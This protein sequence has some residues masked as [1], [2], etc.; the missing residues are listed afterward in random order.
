MLSKAERRNI[1]NLEDR[2]VILERTQLESKIL[3]EKQLELIKDLKRHA[4][5]LEE[6]VAH[7]VSKPVTLT[8]KDGSL[9][10][11]WQGPDSNFDMR[12]PQ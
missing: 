7:L 12:F 11:T 10:E 6:L 1:V 5:Y 3:I 8:D 9:R 4:K 2:K